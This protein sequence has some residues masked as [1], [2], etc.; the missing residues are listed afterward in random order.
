M[1]IMIRRMCELYFF[2]SVVLFSLVILLTRYIVYLTK[3]NL[4]ISTSI[5]FG[6]MIGSF[7][8]LGFDF[9]I[10]NSSLLI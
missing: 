5:S 6:R 8:M 2:F 10:F 9:V 7:F 1:M 3:L 4:I